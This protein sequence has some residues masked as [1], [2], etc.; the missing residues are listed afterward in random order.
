MDKITILSDTHGNVSDLVKLTRIMEE[1]DYVFFAGDGLKDFYALPYEI[2]KKLKAVS[3]NCDFLSS[4]KELLLTVS[5]KRI[6]ICHGD[7]YGVKSGLTKLSLRA[8]ELNCDVVVYGHTHTPSVIT[9]DGVTYVNPGTLSKHS[10][11][12]TFA[13]MVIGNGKVVATINNS[14]F[15]NY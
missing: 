7:A 9:Y 12:K 13:Y 1:S 14:F 11:T 2:T 4:K 15:K 10:L 3:G 8:K 6:F 5:D